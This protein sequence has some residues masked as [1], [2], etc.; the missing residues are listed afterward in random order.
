MR[1]D[2][3]ALQDAQRRAYNRIG[4]EH[5]HVNHD[6][7]DATS[8]HHK[9]PTL[10]AMPFAMVPGA[11]PGATAPGAPAGHV[12]AV[13]NPFY[14]DPKLITGP[15]ELIQELPWTGQQSLEFD[16][17]IQGPAHVAGQDNNV[18]LTA[19]NYFSVYGIK[20]WFGLSGGG[21]TVKVGANTVPV[22]SSTIYFSNSPTG[23]PGDWGMYNSNVSF[24]I[25]SNVFVDKFQGLQLQETFWGLNGMGPY[26]QYN[27]QG[28]VLINP[29]RLIRGDS[30]IQKWI[31]T[32]NQ[33]LV[34][35]NGNP[36]P[37]TPSA[38]I[39]CR[40]VGLLGQKMG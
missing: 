32:L 11:P 16:F 2:Q 10:K 12:W 40:L 34:D 7:A 31:I 29:Q 24:K 18:L 33:P 9:N 27:E 13:R 20:I 36:L 17:S 8:P 30:G 23:A 35:A 38:V 6:P 21:Y 14:C 26:V 19:N 28:L 22:S 3:V 1:T 25:E 4:Q 5:I 15:T 39:S 37:I